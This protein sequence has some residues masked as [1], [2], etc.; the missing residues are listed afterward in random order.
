[1]SNTARLLQT[2]DEDGIPGNGISITAQADNQ[3]IAVTADFAANDFEQ[4]VT[5]LVA[6]LGAYYTS[7]ISAQ[8]A[9][10]HLNLTLGNTATTKN[11]GTDSSKMGYKGT[12]S[13]LA[14]NVSGSAT[15]IDNCTIEI[16]MFNFDS[17]APNVRFYAGVNANFSDSTAFGI[18]ERIDGRNYSNET[19]VLELP[20]GKFVD[21]FDSLSVGC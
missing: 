19:I 9:L 14:H 3:A 8:S 20:E 13:T 11:C 5:E 1:V 16:T 6:N 2:L 18:G 4:Q 17:A 21:D 7:L 10:E 15:V 12:F